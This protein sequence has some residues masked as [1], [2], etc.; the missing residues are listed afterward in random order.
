M[1]RAQVD[2]LLAEV[3]EEFAFD[4]VL[5]LYVF[6]WSLAGLGADRSDPGFTDT[7]REAY[8]IF[9]A[10]HPELVLVWVPWP[11]DVSQAT[12]ADPDTLVDLDLD[13]EA[14]ADV[15]LL[16]L[17]APHRLGGDPAQP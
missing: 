13:P 5:A 11:V 4:E 7:C 3:E 15:R 9:R 1:N 12:V 16:A 17:V 14:P 2:A 6:A 10:R 8:D